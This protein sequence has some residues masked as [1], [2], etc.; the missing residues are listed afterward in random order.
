VR[1]AALA[2]LFFCKL[3]TI[4]MHDEAEGNA[5][6]NCC[7]CIRDCCEVLAFYAMERGNLA[8]TPRARVKRYLHLTDES[9]TPGKLTMTPD[10]NKEQ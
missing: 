4:A 8:G 3:T 10:K 6:Y 7:S 5:N 9:F 2:F 1:K